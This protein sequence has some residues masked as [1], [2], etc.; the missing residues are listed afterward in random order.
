MNNKRRS[1]R[2]LALGV[3]MMLVTEPMALWAQTGSGSPSGLTLPLAVEIALRTN[4]LVQAMASQREIAAAEVEQAKAARLPRL[5]FSETFTHSNNPVFAFGTLLEQGRFGPQNLAIDVLNNPASLSNFRTAINL[6]LPLFKQLQ[7]TTRI[8]QAHLAEQKAEAQQ[9][10]V[11]QQ[12]RFQVIRAYY[13]VLVAEAQKEVADEAVR[14]AE[15]DVERIRHLFEQGVV[16][17][18]DLLATEVQLAEFRQQQ[19]QAQGHIRTAYAALNT[20]LGLPTDTPQTIEGQLQERT[21]HVPSQAELM[22][23]ALRH[24]PDYRQATLDVRSR[25]QGI[26]GALGQYLPRLNL[27]ASFGNSG[28][29]LASGSTDFTV[30]AGLTFQLFDW[31]RRARIR[32][33]RAARRAAQA[34]QQRKA[35]EIRLD[36]VRAYQDFI[37]ARERLKVA[38]RAVDQAEETLRIVQDRYE[39]GLT[40]ITEVLRARTALVRARM[41]LLSARYDYYVG[42]ARTLLVSGRLRDVR[43]FTN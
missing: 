26:R 25:Q 3:V 32:Q 34:Q 19:I 10:L 43:P 1:G 13:G 22:D 14:M 11:R 21:F 9:E 6:S 30:G 17:A 24:R 38:S 20:A 41:N 35:D 31:G 42:Y 18:S 2:L 29:G 8:A 7:T 39:V 15:A 16:V 28:R 37:S 40:T 36:V 33:A 12:I 23:L 4:P 27:F 5:E